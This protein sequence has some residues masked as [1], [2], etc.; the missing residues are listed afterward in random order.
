MYTKSDER[1]KK[2]G[3][4]F[5]PEHIVKD[6]LS[7]LEEEAWNPEKTFLDPACGNGNI[8]IEVLKEKISHGIDPEKALSTIYGIDIMPDNIEECKT[9]LLKETDVK[10]KAIV[11]KNIK[12]GN[13][14]L[15]DLD[16]LFE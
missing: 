9:R 1:V 11:D 12:C 15:D 8:L 10:Y 5:T 4:V 13:F 7:F 3:E 16:K 2:N 6:M 14:L